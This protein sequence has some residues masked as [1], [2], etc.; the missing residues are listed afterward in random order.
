MKYVNFLFILFICICIIKSNQIKIY[1]KKAIRRSL[2]AA[3]IKSTYFDKKFLNSHIVVFFNFPFFPG[4]LSIDDIFLRMIEN[5]RIIIS[6][7]LKRQIET[8]CQTFTQP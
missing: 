2:Q 6:Q 3:Q 5:R 7:R 8:Y 1:S 4:L